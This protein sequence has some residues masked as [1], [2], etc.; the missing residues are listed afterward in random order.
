M[1]ESKRVECYGPLGE[2]H[3]WELFSSNVP[4]VPQRMHIL[5]KILNVESIHKSK[6]VTA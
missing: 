6:P 1:V 4:C 3:L 2:H 5:K